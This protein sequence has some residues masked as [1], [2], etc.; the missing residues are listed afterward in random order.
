MYDIIM[1]ESESKESKFISLGRNSIKLDYNLDDKNKLGFSLPVCGYNNNYS[2][3]LY[4]DDKIMGIYFQNIPLTIKDGRVDTNIV[5]TALNKFVG[6]LKENGF[7]EQDIIGFGYKF[8]IK[9]F[10]V[11]LHYPY[12][13][14]SKYGLFTSRRLDINLEKYITKEIT[15]LINGEQITPETLLSGTAFQNLN[16]PTIDMDME[17]WYS[18]EEMK[19]YKIVNK[20]RKGEVDGISY[21]IKMLDVWVKISLDEKSFLETENHIHPDFINLISISLKRYFPIDSEEYNKVKEDIIQKSE[22]YR[23]YINELKID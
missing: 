21:D 16:L 23:D 19:L 7:T 17:K 20:I 12:D 9:F 18:I 13:F 11:N 4:N 14:N 6:V 22:I 1:E 2:Y 5:N 3:I 10:N 15:D 8:I